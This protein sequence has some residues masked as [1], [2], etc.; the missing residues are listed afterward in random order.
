MNPDLIKQAAINCMKYV[1]DAQKQAEKHGVTIWPWIDGWAPF[2][3]II[4]AALK[5]K[6]YK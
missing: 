1:Q 2:E 4:I 3:Q 5:N 6:E